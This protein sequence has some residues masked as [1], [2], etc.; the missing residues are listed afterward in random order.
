MKQNIVQVASDDAVFD[1]SLA[2]ASVSWEL[3]KCVE[4][5]PFREALKVRGIQHLPEDCSPA[6]ALHRMMREMFQDRNCIIR[7]VE[8]PTGSK[9][10]AYA[11]LPRED[12]GNKMAFKQKWSCGIDIV[13]I[14]ASADVSLAFSTDDQGQ[15]EVEP[16]T[17]EDMVTQFPAYL[18]QLG[19]EELS[20]WLVGLVK[21]YLQGV[22][23]IG[24]AG[25]FFIGPKEVQTWRQLREAVKPFGIR[26]YEIPAMRSAEALECVVESVKRYTS[27]ACDELQEDLVKYQEL[28]QL[29]KTNPKI[30]DIQGR[31][32]AERTK[33]I[34]EQM[35]FVEKYESLFD[36]KLNEL[37]DS[38]SSLQSG[39]GNLTLIGEALEQSA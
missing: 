31:V 14:G 39:F 7:P 23:T 26:L 16:S 3:V 1:R 36:V 34:S 9:R 37:R 35:A 32:I 20:M 21:S 28:K 24:G 10:P 5:E 25:T 15:M 38:L 8:N 27:K 11:V 22:P 13:S 29:R 12:D 18:A 30:R 4:T 33:R 2:G 17:I 19:A 6:S